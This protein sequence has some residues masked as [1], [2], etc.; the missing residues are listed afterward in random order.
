MVGT[1][2][3]LWSV[4]RRT[5]LADPDRPHLCFRIV[6][7]LNIAVIAGFPAALVGYFL[8]NRLLPAGMSDRIVWEAHSLFLTWLALAC[9]ALIGPSRQVWRN[10]AAAGAKLFEPFR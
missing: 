4:K 7:R 6:E 9:L 8:S 2:L 1:G 10:L 3:I 5:R